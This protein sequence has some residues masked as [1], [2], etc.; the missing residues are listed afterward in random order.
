MTV[1]PTEPVGSVPRPAYLQEAMTAFANA[2][3]SQQELD[4]LTNQALQETIAALEQ[5]GS[6]VITDGE[7]AKPSFA[8]Y[9]ITG[10]EG[11]QPN[12]VVIPFA[13]GHTRQLPVISKG[14]FHYTTT[15][16]TYL[17]RAKTFTNRP[18]KQA[19]IAVSALSLLYPQDGIDGYSQESFLADL[20]NEAEKEIRNCLDAG[21]YNVQIDF[22][23]G[24]LALKLDPSK[25]LLQAFID[26]NN[27]VLAR[28]SPEEQ[29]RIGVHSCPGGDH[30]STHS[31]DISYDDLLPALFDLKAGNFY[32]EYAAEKNKPGVLAAIKANLKPNQRVFLGVT[33]VLDPQVE[34]AEQIRDLILEAAQTIPVNQLGTTDDCG[35]SPFADDVSTARDIAFAKIKARIEGTAL[36]EKALG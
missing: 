19:V 11:L 24:R 27:Q 25:Q 4:R 6:P 32:L 14:P 28:F 26:L 22:T 12:G 10:L 23:E 17:K 29:A 21:A 34:T 1:L 8:T 18:I 2:Q 36:A 13:D 9:P 20:V 31:A 5:T 7:Q 3:I 30:D 35:F 15:A 16:D 33:N